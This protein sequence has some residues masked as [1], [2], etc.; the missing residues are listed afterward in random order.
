MITKK[1]LIYREFFDNEILYYFL[2]IHKLH[3]KR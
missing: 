1:K 2:K 3:F